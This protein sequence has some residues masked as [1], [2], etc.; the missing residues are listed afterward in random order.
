[1]YIH[2]ICC[3]MLCCLICL[4]VQFTHTAFVVCRAQFGTLEESI[5]GEDVISL[6]D[7]VPHA[8]KCSVSG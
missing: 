2:L 7:I 8:S 4:P 5:G 3:F 6:S 1:M